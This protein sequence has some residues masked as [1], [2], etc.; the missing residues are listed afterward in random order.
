V[1]IKKWMMDNFPK[2][3][4]QLNEKKKKEKRNMLG[5]ERSNKGKS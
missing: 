5:I 3:A 4:W 2:K 1:P